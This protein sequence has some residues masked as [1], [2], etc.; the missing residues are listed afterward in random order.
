MTHDPD[1]VAT[2]DGSQTLRHQVT[3][4]TYHSVNGAVA[5]S[6]HV[7][8]RNGFEVS[9]AQHVRILEAGFG[10]GLNALMTLRAAEEAGRSVDYTAI[11]LYPVN[12]QTAAQMAYTADDMFIPLHQAAWNE[13]QSITPN[14]SLTKIHGDLADTRFDTIFD[15][16][17]YDAFAPDSQPELWTEEIFRRIYLAMSAGGMLLTYSAKG[18]VKRA[19]RAAGFEVHRLE[20]APGKRHMLRAIKKD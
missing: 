19:L 10:S 14:F 3:G 5:E 12:I 7:F 4:E 20:G 8:I 6:R 16:V 11:E 1:I 17:Y 18:D 9:E 2:S 15:I 13:K